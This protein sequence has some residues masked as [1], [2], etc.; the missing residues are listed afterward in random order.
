MRVFVFFTTGQKLPAKRKYGNHL[1][2]FS[3]F[4]V[5]LNF[6]KTRNCRF[7]KLQGWISANPGLK[8]NTVLVHLHFG[9]FQDFG[10][11][12]F[13]SVGQELWENISMFMNKLLG[14]VL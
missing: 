4:S 11:Y 13:Y 14:S 6:V 3:R 5:L 10:K 9:L 7:F 1:V 12:N 2:K 8:F